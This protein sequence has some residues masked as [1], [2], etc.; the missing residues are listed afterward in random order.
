MNAFSLLVGISATL[1]LAWTA[2]RMP[3]APQAT[4]E[5]LIRRELWVMIGALLGARIAYLLPN[6]PYFIHQPLDMIAF[7]EG[8]LSWTG[9]LPGAV[10]A[11]VLV[12]RQAN[13]G[14]PRLADAILPTALMI[15]LGVWLGCWQTGV[16]Y[17]VSLKPELGWGIPAVDETGA[18]ALRVPVQP[19]GALITL[20][21][22]ILVEQSKPPF[23][24]GMGR[25]GMAVLMG[26]TV[27]LLALS[28]FR[29][30]PSPKWL[31]LRWES[32]VGMVYLLAETGW[33]L[34]SSVLP[35]RLRSAVG[36]E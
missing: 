19:L 18:Y 3:N 6:L 22:F 2:W 11:V 12:G 36:M 21:W 27:L 7:W 29:A 9:A 4:V 1:G 26:E 35:H 31:G 32:W 24:H 20:L 23:L 33:A 17:G 30:D 34:R 14:I 25:K 13:Q 8:G 15:C 5:R 10:L 28:F 16:A